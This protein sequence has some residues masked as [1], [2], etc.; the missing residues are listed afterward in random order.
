[1][2][3][4]MRYIWESGKVRRTMHIMRFNIIGEMTMQALCGIRHPFDR[5]INAPWGLG[6]HIC[7]RCA[8]L[9]AE[10]DPHA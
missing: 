3:E 5:S 4:G 6:R 1:M 10:E 7:K 8:A 2:S 9:A